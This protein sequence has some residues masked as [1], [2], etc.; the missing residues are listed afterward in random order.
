MGDILTQNMATFDD[1]LRASFNTGFKEA[2]EDF[3]KDLE[4]VL[5]EW[6]NEKNYAQTFEIP[7]ENPLI[8]PP[9]IK[10]NKG[11]EDLMRMIN[12]CK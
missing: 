3:S 12:N 11:M 7:E 1:L 8:V 5:K 2:E 10:F 4:L 6:E 9:V